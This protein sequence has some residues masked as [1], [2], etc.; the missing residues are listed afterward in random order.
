VILDEVT[1]LEP[2]VLLLD[3]A[4][5]RLELGSEWSSLTEILH[6]RGAPDTQNPG[7]TQVLRYF[8]HVLLLLL[9]LSSFCDREALT[10]IQTLLF[11]NR[12]QKQSIRKSL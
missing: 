2:I 12:L 7:I 6:R 8:N 11:Y 1:L 3:Y 4:N 5:Y 9:S 10:L